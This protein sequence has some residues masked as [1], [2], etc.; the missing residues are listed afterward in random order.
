[1]AIG[2]ETTGATITSGAVTWDLELDG[3]QLKVA[4]ELNA[5][6][7][8]ISGRLRPAGGVEVKNRFIVKVRSIKA[9]HWENRS[10]LPSESVPSPKG[11][12][13][14]QTR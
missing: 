2:A 4:S 7:V 12:R 3:K 10:F 6:K 13:V 1:M 5:G 9:V 8:I 14:L 11:P